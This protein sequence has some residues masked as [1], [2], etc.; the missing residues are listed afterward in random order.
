MALQKEQ[1][2]QLTLAGILF[3]LAILFFILLGPSD[4]EAL[5]Y[6][7]DESEQ[8]LF[9]APA[10]SIPPIKGIND[11]QF[12]GVR[13][14][15]IAPKGQCGDKSARRIAYLEKWSPQFKQHLEAAARAKANGQAVPN[16]VDRSQRKFHRFVRLEDSPQW[17]SLNTDQAAKIIAALRTKD[18]QG[19]FPEP[20]TPN[21]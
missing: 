14:I 13:A 9:T 11:D 4:R 6:F 21:N 19:K 18:A 8:K 12:D 10:D 7:Y 20:C 16:I 5:Q 2:K 17:Y 3:S 1:K 15:V